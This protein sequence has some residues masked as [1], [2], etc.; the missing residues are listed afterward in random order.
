MPGRA[1]RCWGHRFLL[2]GS[3]LDRQF[4]FLPPVWRSQPGALQNFPFSVSSGSRLVQT[5]S[6]PA[7]P[8]RPSEVTRRSYRT[9]GGRVELATLHKLAVR[10]GSLSTCMGKLRNLLYLSDSGKASCE[11]EACLDG[12]FLLASPPTPLAR[13]WWWH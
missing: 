9:S 13:E 11:R 7:I 2:R 10:S 5:S 8:V 6:P 12:T 3:P 4:I 1:I